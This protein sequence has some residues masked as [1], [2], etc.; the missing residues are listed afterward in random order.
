MKILPDGFKVYHVPKDEF[1]GIAHV[2]ILGL[3]GDIKKFIDGASKSLLPFERT[4][5]VP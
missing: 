3:P 2:Y 4:K 5:G 1:G